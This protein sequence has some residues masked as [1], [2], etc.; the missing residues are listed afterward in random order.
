MLV[1]R[2]VRGLVALVCT[3]LPILTCWLLIVWKI[4]QRNAL[5][6]SQAPNP[7]KAPMRM[8]GP[9]EA[10]A[11]IDPWF[12]GTII[13][14]LYPCALFV[15]GYTIWASGVLALRKDAKA[16]LRIICVARLALISIILGLFPSIPWLYAV[17]RILTHGLN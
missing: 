3:L 10:L 4:G 17:S 11:Y 5:G 7:A 6:T 15:C 16:P 2:C 12:A 8:F 9:V 1:K 14:W 13:F